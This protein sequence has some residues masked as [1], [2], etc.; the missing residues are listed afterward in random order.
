MA[1][2]EEIRTQPEYGIEPWEDEE[3]ELVEVIDA[4]EERETAQGD[5]GGVG[6]PSQEQRQE[7]A[8]QEH[9]DEAA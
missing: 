8:L 9:D 4:S 7:T 5:G 6:I 2:I 3:L 1:K